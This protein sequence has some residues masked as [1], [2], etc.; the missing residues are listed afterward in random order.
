MPFGHLDI[1][2]DARVLE[3]RPWTSSQSRWAAEL[4]RDVD[5]PARVLELC[6]GAGHIGLLALS[7]AGS[8]STPHRLVTV[9]TNPVAC[10]HARRNAAAAGLGPLV[11]V[12]E[13][14]IDAA[15]APDER[16]DLVIADPPWVSR[17]ETGRFPD[18]PLVAIDG[19]PDGLDVAWECLRAGEAHLVPGG[20]ILLQLGSAEQDQQVRKRVPSVA[21]RLAVGESRAFGTHGVLVRLTKRPDDV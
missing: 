11:D 2:Y 14:R 9:D 19:G 20:S 21:P 3:P 4:L 5:P 16:F 6:A 15:L 13:A 18:D 10:Y 1:G 17:A 7:L 12:R 8:P